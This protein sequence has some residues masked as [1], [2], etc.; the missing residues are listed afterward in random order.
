M[1]ES[2]KAFKP[3]GKFLMS[4][5]RDLY[6]IPCQFDMCP[7]FHKRYIPMATCRRCY[8]IQRIWSVLRKRE[9]PKPK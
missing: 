6:A 2:T 8:M 7:G 3:W 4:L 5:Q 1:K 9:V